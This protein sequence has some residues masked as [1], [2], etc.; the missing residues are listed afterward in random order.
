[1]IK[2]TMGDHSATLNRIPLDMHPSRASDIDLAEQ[3]HCQE[4]LFKC[5]PNELGWM[6]LIQ[7][8]DIWNCHGQ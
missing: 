6:V 2:E 5:G 3:C 8:L 4:G 1:M 7:Y